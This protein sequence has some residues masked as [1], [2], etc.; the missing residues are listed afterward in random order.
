MEFVLWKD[1]ALP[2]YCKLASPPLWSTVKLHAGLSV[3]DE[4]PGGLVYSMSDLFPDDIV[5]RDNFEVAGQV[6]ISGRL[7]S[8]LA[9]VLQG[10]SIEF[11]P[12]SIFNHK[13][14]LAS[15]D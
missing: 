7:R 4:Y 11:L 12:V 10:H 13:D 15:D 1:V 2:G 5:L 8:H 9:E 14:R 3:V 6:L